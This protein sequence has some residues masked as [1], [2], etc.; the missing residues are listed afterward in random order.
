MYEM[1][2]AEKNGS[3][4]TKNWLERNLFNRNIKIK[5]KS[6]PFRLPPKSKIKAN[7]P[8]LA[9]NLHNNCN[10]FLFLN[11]QQLTWDLLNSSQ[12]RKPSRVKHLTDQAPI[13]S[14]GARRNAFN[15]SIIT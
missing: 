7:H 5:K 10:I 2:I 15:Q 8:K 11:W 9:V 3:K 12:L 6:S 1:S 14:L 4:D 13:G